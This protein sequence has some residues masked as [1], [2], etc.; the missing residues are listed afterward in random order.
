MST[1]A[2]SGR[3]ANASST[4]SSDVAA[5]PTT[6]TPSSARSCLAA[7]KNSR[8]SSTTKQVSGIA[9]SRI[10]DTAAPA[11]DGQ[12]PS[13]LRASRYAAAGCE[14]RSDGVDTPCMAEKERAQRVAIADWSRFD[15]EQFRAGMDV[16]FEHGSHDPQT[17]VTHERPDP[18]RQ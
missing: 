12:R 2:T 8:L 1:S 17:D 16:E 11:P 14:P 13:R 9:P 4:A 10:A 7:S 15:V 5:K 3:R 6:V 18:H